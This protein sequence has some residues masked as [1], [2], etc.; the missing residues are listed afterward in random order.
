METEIFDLFGH[1]IYVSADHRFGTDALLLAEFA[2]PSAKDVVCDLCSGCGIIPMLFFAW[3]KAPAKAYAVEIQDEA[4]ALMKMTVEKNCIS[5]RF[6]PVH[7]DLTKDDELSAVPYGGISLVTVN[8]PYY[9]SGSGEERLSPAQA[10]ARHELL[11]DLE[12]VVCAASKLLKYGG[13]LKM[14]HLPE[15]IADIFCLMRKYGI[16]P[17]VMR[18]AHHRDTSTKPYLVLVSGKKGGKPGLIVE[19]PVTVE[20]MDR[21]LFG[22]RYQCLQDGC[23][24]I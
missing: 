2:K 18:F 16:E 1:D 15:R 4:A 11:C 3:G 6:I 21:R 13:Y 9:K 8:P 19:T 12:S 24:H 20:E 7:A 14:C 22:K 23:E 10:N 5:D 17:K